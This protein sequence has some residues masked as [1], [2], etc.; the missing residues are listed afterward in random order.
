MPDPPRAGER[1]LIALLSEAAEKRKTDSEQRLLK[2][3]RRTSAVSA[4]PAEPLEKRKS[5][6]ATESEQLWQQEAPKRPV[7]P[8]EFNASVPVDNTVGV[9]PSNDLRHKLLRKR[10][11][12]AGAQA[13][14]AADPADMDFSSD[15]D[16]VS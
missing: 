6:V 15:D 9:I 1:D 4:E 10:S 11:R 2:R 3:R 13:D 7:S 14:N 16:C 8:I 5:P 12:K